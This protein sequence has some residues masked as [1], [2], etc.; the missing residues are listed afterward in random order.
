LVENEL[1]I[2][3]SKFGGHPD[4][5]NGQSWPDYE[6]KPQSFIGQINLAEIAQ[7]QLAAELP[8]SG[9]LSFFVFSDYESGEIPTGKVIYAPDTSNLQR[10]T[11]DKPLD[12]GNGLAPECELEFE[13]TLDMPYVSL[14]DLDQPYADEMI[15]CRRAKLLGLNVDHVDAYEELRQALMPNREGRSHLLGWSHPQV[16]GDDLIDENSRNLITVASEEFCDWNWGDGHQLFYGIANED[17]KSLS[18]D[19][20]TSV[21]G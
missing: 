2:G 19:R 13:E 6:G 9:L 1:P 8:A 7:T 14:Y 3:V 11:P 12:E 20:V 15:G 10:R 17:L 21:D 16:A 5:P 4:L 18:F